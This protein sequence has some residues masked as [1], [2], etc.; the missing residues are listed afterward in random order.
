LCFFHSLNHS[1]YKREDF[2]KILSSDIL[3]FFF[4]GVGLNTFTPNRSTQ[5]AS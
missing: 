4:F 3:E 1:L 2:Y 5:E